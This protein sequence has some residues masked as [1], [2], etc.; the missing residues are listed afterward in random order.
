METKLFKPKRGKPLDHDFSGLK[1][2][3]AVKF[4]GNAV[5]NPYPY[6]TRWNK[7]NKTKIEVWRDVAGVPY[8]KRVK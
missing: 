7:A 8:A 4:K 1:L 2:G 3:Q 5:K 6:A